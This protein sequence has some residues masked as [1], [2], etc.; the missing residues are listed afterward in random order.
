MKPLLPHHSA[1]LSAHPERS[2]EWL[3]DRCRDGFDIHHID[4]NHG[5][6]DPANLVL[7][8]HRDHMMLH[9]GQRLKGRAHAANIKDR[10]KMRP[11]AI[12]RTCYEMRSMG[13]RWTDVAF[14]VGI[15]GEGA[16][17]KATSR[18]QKYAEANGL[19]LPNVVRTYG[20]DVRR[21]GDRARSCTAFTRRA[22]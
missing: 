11:S 15:D 2:E 13:Y 19:S 5:N 21:N 8:E 7:I 12:G 20:A 17:A 18:A 22:G 3:R 4:G 1:W 10:L 6:N 14:L 9:A 16:G